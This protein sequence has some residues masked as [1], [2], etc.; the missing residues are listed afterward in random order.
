[1][2][3]FEDIGFVGPFNLQG[4]A[5]PNTKQQAPSSREVPN[6]KVWTEYM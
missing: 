1:V 5:E 6:L 2:G 4:A 3:G